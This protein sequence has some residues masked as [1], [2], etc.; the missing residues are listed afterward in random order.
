MLNKITLMGR[1]TRDPET[2]FTKDNTSVCNFALAV[3]RDAKNQKGE[4][5]TDFIECV[6]W[7]HTADFIQKYF[8]KGQLAVVAGRLNTRDWIDKEGNKR[9]TT[10]VIVENIYFS[11]EKKRTSTIPAGETFGTFLDISDDDV[12]PF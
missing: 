7:R 8:S 10:E 1:F 6:A 5:D 9:K 4:Y 11:G 2:R 12:I 3:D